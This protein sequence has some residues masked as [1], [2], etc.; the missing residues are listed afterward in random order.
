MVYLMKARRKDTSLVAF[1][2]TK[3]FEI[4]FGDSD[5]VS[6]LFVKDSMS[7]QNAGQF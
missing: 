5:D 3:P 1:M 6:E 7:L 2:K 4:Y